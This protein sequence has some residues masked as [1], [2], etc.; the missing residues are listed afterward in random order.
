MYFASANIPICQPIYTYI[1]TTLQLERPSESHL[2]G[3]QTSES[4]ES[5]GEE[6]DQEQTEN[7][8]MA[9]AQRE[10]LS[11]PEAHYKPPAP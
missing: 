8:E 9:V 10:S 3:K 6:R 1:N 2:K 11:S 5:C 7:P 4:P